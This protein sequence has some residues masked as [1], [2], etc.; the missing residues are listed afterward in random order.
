MYACIVGVQLPVVAK[1]NNNNN[2]NEVW[3]QLVK[4]L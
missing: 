2:S 3:L 4:C 1:F